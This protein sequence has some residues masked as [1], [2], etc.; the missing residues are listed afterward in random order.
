M[1]SN[2]RHSQSLTPS[3]RPA[4]LPSYIQIEQ[5]SIKIILVGYIHVGRPR[6]LAQYCHEDSCHPKAKRKSGYT[7]HRHR[8]AL[9]QVMRHGHGADALGRIHHHC[10][11]LPMLRSPAYGGL[12]PYRACT[13]T[14]HEPVGRSLT[15]TGKTRRVNVYYEKTAHNNQAK[16]PCNTQENSV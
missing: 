7:Q 13:G 6:I 11:S 2:K 3:H 16:D 15:G 9:K 5:Y 1:S 12:A 14:L 4:I 8:M 10:G